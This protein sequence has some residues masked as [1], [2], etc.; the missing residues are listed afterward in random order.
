MSS[1]DWNDFLKETPW[2]CS[3]KDRVDITPTTTLQKSAFK[4]N[5][6]FRKTFPTLSKLLKL[7][8][9]TEVKINGEISC[10]YGWTDEDDSSFGW[11]STTPGVL[12]DQHN[13]SLHPDHIL[14]LS[15]FGGIMERWNEPD[16]WLTNLDS[17][18]CA[19]KTTVGFAR[20]EE[21]YLEQCKHAQIEP[22]VTPI[23][24]RTF[25]HEA[26]GDCFIYNIKTGQVLMF[27]HDPSMDGIKPLDGCPT[28]TLYTIDDCPNLRT[29]VETIAEQW[30]EYVQEAD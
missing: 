16:S 21:Y 20:W 6:Q 1:S 25:A 29:W 3:E 23:N 9:V 22:T 13:M 24:Y 11:Q 28:H 8:R 17:A 26:N 12:P 7:S 18:L 30:L 10:I 19:S 14:L 5:P 15:C 27:S 2:L 4:L